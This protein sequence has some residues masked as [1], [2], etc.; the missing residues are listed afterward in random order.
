VTYV[1]IVAVVLCSVPAQ[2][3]ALEELKWNDRNARIPDEASSVQCVGSAAR[4]VCV[5]DKTAAPTHAFGYPNYYWRSKDRRYV[6]EV[7]EFNLGRS[8]C[9]FEYGG[10][11]I[12]SIRCV[13]LSK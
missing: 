5:G 11:S 6:T 3:L 4:K 13:G 12:S 8:A 7:W 2:S 1:I 9:W 10:G